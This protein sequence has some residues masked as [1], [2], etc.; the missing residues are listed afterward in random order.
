MRAM[1]DSGV[2]WIGEMPKLW[3][4]VP[5][6]KLA[7]F[8]NGFAFSSDWLSPEASYPVIRIGDIGD[9]G[10]I[11]FAH[12]LGVAVADNL[13]GFTIQKNDILIAMSGATTGKVGFVKNNP[14]TSFINQRVG[15]IRSDK[16]N[17]YLFYCLS[18]NVFKEYV[19][20]LAAGSAQPNLSTEGIKN[21]KVMCPPE[22]ELDE[23]I[24]YLD[25]QCSEIDKVLAKTR[26]S[27]DE[28]KK[29]KQSVIT[30]A[31]TKGIR[32]DRPM[33]PSGIEWIGDIPEEWEVRPMK[34][35]G[36]YR[37]GL[38]Y[39]PEN[40]VDSDSGILVLRSSNIQRGRIELEDNVFVD[41]EIPE[42]LRVKAGDIL[43]CSRNGSR[44]LIGKNAIIPENLNASFGAFMMIFRC[45]FPQYIYYILNSTVF[46]YYLGS[47]L[48]ATINQ[49]TGKNFGSMNVVFCPDDNERQEIVAYLDRQCAEI[50]RLIAKKEQII[51][52]LESY[53]KSLI[54]ECVTGKL[55]VE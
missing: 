2:E 43:I 42:Q 25:Q 17:K 29:L 31:V 19:S 3:A 24:K 41:Q 4:Q 44:D 15:I 26:E 7:I 46:A 39:A 21:Y 36:V 33:K 40:V 8:I 48:T 10:S 37:N 51:T 1:K 23:I 6:K 22:N 50:D 45:Q 53:K 54:Y 11:D 28:Y 34:S 5:V 16:Y 35:L 20:L 52:E 13:T 38:T 49:L 32:P 12:A 27:I 55:E 9:N 47:F 18:T 30:E 14:P